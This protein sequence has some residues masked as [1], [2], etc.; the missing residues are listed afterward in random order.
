MNGLD[1]I[2]LTL[3]LVNLILGYAF[4]LLRRVI[5]FIGLFAGVGFATLASPGVAAAAMHSFDASQALW[6]HA[7]AYLVCI[8]ATVALFEGMGA[9][10]SAV[11]YRY[12]SVMLDHFTGALAGTLAG[13]VQVVLLLILGVNL[14]QS[15]LPTGYP[16]PPRYG[17]MRENFE[18]SLLAGHFF[19]LEPVTHLVFSPV[20]PANLRSYFTQTL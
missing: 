20:L 17:E 14:L 4:G 2:I 13:A 5:S 9:V 19:T 11:L 10:Y 16:Y 12:S 6:V 3:V 8:V 18:S 1:V 7:G 15:N